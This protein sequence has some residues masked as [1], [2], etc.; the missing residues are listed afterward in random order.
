M[1]TFHVHL[2]LCAGCLEQAFQLGEYNVQGI[3]YSATHAR[4]FREQV[5]DLSARLP[6]NVL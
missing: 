1:M 4:Q 3:W 5:Q 6:F 2:T